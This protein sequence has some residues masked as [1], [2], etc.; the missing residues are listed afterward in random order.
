MSVI[1]NKVYSY[2]GITEY[3]EHGAF[4]DK[5]KNLIST[6]L[7]STVTENQKITIPE[8]AKYVRFT[9]INTNT[10]IDNFQLEFGD[11]AT[12]QEA[13]MSNQVNIVLT[14]PLRS[15]SDEVYDRIYN[16]ENKWYDEQKINSITLNGTE[17]DWVYNANQD[18]TNTVFFQKVIADRS[19]KYG[20]WG[21]PI[22]CDKFINRSVWNIDQEG[23]FLQSNNGVLM[24]RV[25]R[26]KLTGTI[27]A[28]SFKDWLVSNNLNVLY[29]LNTPITVEITDE[30][31]LQA[32]NSIKTYDEITNIITD[33]PLKAVYYK[34]CSLT[35]NNNG[36]QQSKPLFKLKGKGTISFDNF[37]YTFP[38]NENAVEIDSEKED[39]YLDK[40][41]K[42]RNM[43]GEFPTLV[44]GNNTITW[45]GKLNQIE[46]VPRSRWL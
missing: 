8:N 15:S 38:E 46:I 5:D 18:K 25:N 14:H 36:S 13:H 42:N 17:T 30:A 7:E 32:L 26:D 21:V 41:L 6:F 35:V 40:T 10:D 12:K 4:Y 29:E 24:I 2:Q 1:A 37:I 34:T 22:M 11:M 19:L 43:R 44:P 31:T 27:G 3:S 20:T 23:I 39:A 33:V 28:A 45:T 16:D 9:I